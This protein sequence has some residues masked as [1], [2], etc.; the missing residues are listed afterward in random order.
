MSDAPVFDLDLAT[1]HADP[2]PA[3]AAMR[4]RAPIAYVPQ[5]GATL[6]T[7]RNTI[8]AQEKR[9]AVFSSHQPAG[10]MTMRSRRGPVAVPVRWD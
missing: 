3:L 7:R 9:I 5:L 10:L 6:I 4:A 2:F 1:F 8:F